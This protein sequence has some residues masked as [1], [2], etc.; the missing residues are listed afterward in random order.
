M[1]LPKP[2]RHLMRSDALRPFVVVL[3]AA[4]CV[5]AIGEAPEV[6]AVREPRIVV[7]MRVTGN[8]TASMFVNDGP[9]VQVATIVSGVRRR[10]EFPFDGDVRFL[11]F[12]PGNAPGLSVELFS[13][14]AENDGGV[15]A[16][17]R[18][19]ELA[20]W[21]AEDMTLVSATPRVIRWRTDG[22]PA[23]ASNVQIPLGMSRRADIAASLDDPV[24]LTALT[25]WVALVVLSLWMPR[26]RSRMAAV[27]LVTLSVI[28][29]AIVYPIATGLIDPIPSV[30][31]A[32][33]NAALLGYGYVGRQVASVVV[34][35]SLLA[36]AV[37]AVLIA[38]TGIARTG[39]PEQPAPDQD[40]A[41]A[42]AALP[43][44]PTPGALFGLAGVGIAALA[45]IPDLSAG[46][47]AARVGQFPASA[48]D[49]DNILTWEWLSSSGRVPMR[50]FWY[51]YG[52]D[53]LYHSSLV[54]G[55]ILQYIV[56][57][58]VLAGLGRAAWVLAQ[59]RWWP[60][61]AVVG[62]VT[63]VSSADIT[64][65]AIPVTVALLYA[66]RDRTV[67]RFQVGDILFGLAV[68]LA[69]FTEAPFVGYAALGVGAVVIVD[70]LEQRGRSWRSW[71]R[72]FAHELIVPL[73]GAIAYVTALLMNGQFGE[74]TGFL[75]TLRAQSAYGAAPLDLERA[76]S[77]PLGPDFVVLVAPVVFVAWG[78]FARTRQDS[79]I[80]NAGLYLLVVGAV[81]FAMLQKYLLRPATSILFFTA[82][83]GSV[84]AV[85]IAWRPIGRYR[86]IGAGLI[87]GLVLSIATVGP[88]LSGTWERTRTLPRR[89]WDN[90]ALVLTKRDEVRRASAVRFGRQH[91]QQLPGERAVARDLRPSLQGVDHGLFV[92][93]NSPM[94]Y[95][96]LEQEPLWQIN[97][98]NMSPIQEQ[99]H[100]LRDLARHHP[101]FVVWDPA[102]ASFD[103][104]QDFVRIPAVYRYVM[105]HYVPERTTAGFDVLVPREKAPFAFDYWERTLGTVAELGAIGAVTELP[106][107]RSC[108]AGAGDCATYLRLRLARSQPAGSAIEVPI[109]VD[110]SPFTV[111]LRAMSDQTD[112]V[113]RLDRLWFWGVAIAEGLPVE[114]ARP[115]AAPWRATIV[116]RHVS[117]DTLY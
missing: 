102:N 55:P 45:L 69:L 38:R 78:S 59:R 35:L 106:D 68:T 15:V 40:A 111:R 109:S 26:R 87:L 7:D 71:L 54:V 43:F 93:S 10:Y 88:E 6:L 86:V 56:Q 58:L 48:F 20:S 37:A 81:S 116:S 94:L 46:V 44:R 23:L 107:S 91:F 57:L 50:D 19:D 108:R 2:L 31:T 36:V 9:D 74:S 52:F 66:A 79:R 64:R 67:D 75:L 105:R 22:V 73:A 117:P 104:V 83:L 90:A 3:V 28:V 72:R 77:D 82:L 110:G 32:V 33:G 29:A 8:A 100:V 49:S 39:P 1:S 13:I 61:I 98:Y 34:L 11:F 18:P 27:A 70:L 25:T 103:G 84:G 99:H 113:V 41:D 85:A 24:A 63:V 60:A 4:G 14:K 112:Y 114:L 92:L 115:P 12:R 53:Y 17:Y 95:T 51:P 89:V 5:A 65:Y 96:L 42:D 16:V 21:G 47:V 62:L 97:T 76:L 101:R 30:T 80:R